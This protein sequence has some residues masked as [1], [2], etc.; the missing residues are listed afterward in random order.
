MEAKIILKKD[1]SLTE[2]KENALL[3]E[4]VLEQIKDEHNLEIEQIYK[5]IYL[6]F[7]DKNIEFDVLIKASTPTGQLRWISVELKEFDVSKVIEQSISRRDFVDYSYIIL[8]NSVKW[9]VQYILYVWGDY[10]KEYKIGFF[11]ND[12]FVL[13]SKFIRKKIEI[14][15]KK[16]PK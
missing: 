5:N 4:S 10:I 1:K 6:R 14:K 16:N 3:T 2:F 9:I 11:S 12:I 13:N 15:P 8:S 7:N